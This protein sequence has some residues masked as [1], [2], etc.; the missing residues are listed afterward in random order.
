MN[1]KFVGPLALLAVLFFGDQIRINRPGHKYRL[2]VEVETS[3]GIKS[4]S[5]V[6]AVHPDRSYSRGGHTQTK[7]DAVLVD[8]G[9][10]KNLVALLAHIDGT[11]D[12]DGMNY[13]ALRAFR[14]TGRNVSFNEMSRLTGKV[15]VTGALI[16]VLLSFTDLGN[17]GSAHTVSPG[18]LAAVL[19]NGF[20]LRGISAEVVPNGLWPLDFGGLLGEPVTRGILAKLPWLDGPDKAAATVL[21]AAGLPGAEG[22]DAREAFTRK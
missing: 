20:Q 3:D 14:A 5:G 8:L 19:G 9:G 13:V 22:I 21:R 1:F 10:G 6:M 12:L 15:P 18:D 11:V 2:T 7:G 16:P 17:P 4:A